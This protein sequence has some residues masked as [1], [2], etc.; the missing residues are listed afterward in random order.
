MSLWERNESTPVR[1]HL[2]KTETEHQIL[3]REF[4]LDTWQKG[5]G[6]FENLTIW[7]KPYPFGKEYTFFKNSQGNWLK[8]SP[9]NRFLISILGAGLKAVGRKE[10]RIS[11]KEIL[12][13]DQLLAC[14]SCLIP[15][16]QK[17]FCLKC[18]I[19]YLVKKNI[20][21]LMPKKISS[22]LYPTS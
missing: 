19:Q 3:E 12:S 2:G 11:S 5:F 15:L 4:N 16:N 14:P 21:I 20:K 6:S 13:V 7:L 18:Q 1:V 22:K 17:L 9:K 10:G 8:P